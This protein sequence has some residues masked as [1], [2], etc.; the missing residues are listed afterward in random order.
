LVVVRLITR[1]NLVGC[2][3]VRRREQ[4]GSREIEHEIEIGRLELLGE[5]DR[6]VGSVR[7]QVDAVHLGDQLGRRM[8]SALVLRCTTLWLRPLRT[9]LG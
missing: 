6:C 9:L 8:F 2:S 1:S 4:L 7:D 5:R 3:A